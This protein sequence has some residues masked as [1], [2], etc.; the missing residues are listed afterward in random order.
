MWKRAALLV[1]MVLVGSVARG[2]EWNKTFT[3]SGRPVLRVDAKD[4]AVTVRAWDQR[5]IAAHVTAPGWKIGPGELE[6]IDHQTGDAVD[7]TLRRPHSE[8]GIG[9][10]AIRIDIQAP[11]NARLD[12][13]TGDGSIRV[14]EIGGEM[15]LVTG[16]GAIEANGVEGAVQ[17]RTGDGSV[18]IRGRLE[19]L[20]L[21]TGDGRVEVNAMPGSRLTS[22]WKIQTGDGSVTVRLPA[23]TETQPARPSRS[24]IS[25]LQ[26]S[27]RG[28]TPN[29]MPRAA[30]VSSTSR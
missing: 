29:L 14:F 12:I 24:I 6:V 16:D 11:R 30:I 5:T 18:H 10:R 21:H 17:A 19:S 1:V 4:A 13:R 20:A 28:C 27:I 7:L 22:P 23:S 25:S 2:E 15:R 26:R 8:W 3:L 9:T